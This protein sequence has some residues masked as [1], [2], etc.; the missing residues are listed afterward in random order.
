MKEP[1]WCKSMIKL[2]GRL[3]DDNMSL[4]NTDEEGL[5]HQNRQTGGL[6]GKSLHAFPHLR[7]GSNQLTKILLGYGKLARILNNLWKKEVNTKFPTSVFRKIVQFLTILKLIHR[8]KSDHGFCHSELSLG[9]RC[10]VDVDAAAEVGWGFSSL[11]GEAGLERSRRM[12]TQVGS[13]KVVI[14]F[15]F[16]DSMA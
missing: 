2:S 6:A 9:I 16:Q 13:I 1:A 15:R 7:L 12:T 4:I 14:S 3:G 5:P 10:K 8:K 11:L